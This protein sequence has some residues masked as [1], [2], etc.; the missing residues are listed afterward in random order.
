MC[1]CMLVIGRSGLQSIAT[2][3]LEHMYVYYRAVNIVTIHDKHHLACAD[4]MLDGS[5]R[6]YTFSAL[7]IVG[8]IFLFIGNVCFPLALGD[9]AVQLHC[10][11]MQVMSA[12]LDSMQGWAFLH[13]QPT[14]SGIF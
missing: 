13:V 8:H 12:Q 11:V 6:G 3:R 14:S 9:A 2:C 7:H 1:L 4:E 10:G 5:R